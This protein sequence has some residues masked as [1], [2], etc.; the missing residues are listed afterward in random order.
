VAEGVL[1]FEVAGSITQTKSLALGALRP[2]G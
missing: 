1:Q 2:S